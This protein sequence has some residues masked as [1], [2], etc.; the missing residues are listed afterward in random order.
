MSHLAAII[1]LVL[2]AASVAYLVVLVDL[3]ELRV[4]F[5]HP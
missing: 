5:G 2:F 4:V 3:W 1:A